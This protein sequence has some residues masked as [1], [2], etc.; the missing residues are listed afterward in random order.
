MTVTIER[1]AFHGW[2]DTWL[3]RGGPVEARVIADVGPRVLEMR[4]RGGPNLFHVRD[5]ELGGRGEATWRMRGGWRLWIAPERHA[6]TYALDNAPCD[7]A[8]GR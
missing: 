3:M 6:T 7:V 4:W 2:E 8:V 1:G 5:G